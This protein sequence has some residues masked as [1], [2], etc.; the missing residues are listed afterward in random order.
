MARFKDFGSGDTDIEPIVFKLHGEE[1]TCFPQIPG[2]FLLDLARNAAGGTDESEAEVIL[3]FFKQ[4][5]EEE[6]Y[7]RFET[8]IEDRHRVVTMEQL[9]E[10]VSWL[11]EEYSDRPEKQPET[12]STGR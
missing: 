12:S 2:K 4:V 8:L 6:S 10:I 7:E 1:F 3:I 9:S 5:L 11:M